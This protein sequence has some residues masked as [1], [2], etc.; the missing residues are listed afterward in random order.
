MVNACVRIF[1]FAQYSFQFKKQKWSKLPN[2]KIL[3]TRKTEYHNCARKYCNLDQ[4]Y[5][6]PEHIAEVKSTEDIVKVIDFANLHNIPISVKTSGHSYYGASTGHQTLGI[7]MRAFPKNLEV[8]SNYLDSSGKNVGNVA[9]VAC[10]MLWGEVYEIIGDDWDIVGGSCPSVSACGGWLAG[11]GLS[12]MGRSYGFGVDNV[13]DF[14]LV[15]P[16]GEVVLVDQHT[17][18]DLFFALRGG[19]GG[20]WGVVTSVHYKVYEPVGH[21]LVGLGLDD[22]KTPAI[23]NTD[24]VL[25]QEILDHWHDWWIRACQD[26]DDRWSGYWMQTSAI[27]IFTGTMADARTTLLDSYDAWHADFLSKFPDQTGLF[28]AQTTK[29]KVSAGTYHKLREAARIGK[30][31]TTGQTEFI[32][33]NKLVPLEFLDDVQ[34]TKEMLW[35][36]T[37][38]GFVHFSYVLGGKQSNPDPGSPPASFHPNMRKSIWQLV[39]VASGYA[40]QPTWSAERTQQEMFDQVTAYVGESG[41]G[42]NHGGRNVV[43]WRQEFWGENYCRL[44]QIKRQVDPCGRFRCW[45]CVGWD[46]PE[47]DGSPAPPLPD[48]CVL[49]EVV[50]P[51]PTADADPTADEDAGEN[52]TSVTLIASA[53]GGL[54][55]GVVFLF[56]LNKKLSSKQN[57]ES[58]ML[59]YNKAQPRLI[60]SI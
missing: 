51:D 27:L 56:V 21:I 35:D 34:K 1:G 42:V 52:T 11:S 25:A 39:F 7:N 50:C 4:E 45:Q 10:G 43:N 32:I 29:Y 24:G 33:N 37:R 28:G 40:A 6:L 20:T 55:A 54:V 49:P 48:T 2:N 14:E 57:Q 31:D 60:P 36:L 22:V 53:A 13:V 46:G 59:A 12:G 47:A 30:S 8:F 16:N 19:G 18:P 44:E 17:E 23:F 58:Q 26:L 9:K 5:N 41:V 3:F 38:N 15:K